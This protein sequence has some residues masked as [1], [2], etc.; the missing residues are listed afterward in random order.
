MTKDLQRYR[1][2]AN[3]VGVLLLLLTAAVIVKYGFGHPGF[4]AVIS[5]IHGFFFLLVY[6]PLAYRLHR[7]AQW[8]TQR[9]LLLL[10]AGIV[11]FA[12]FV[13]ERKVTREL[14]ERM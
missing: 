10:A 3:T 9:L 12:T 1:I 14:Q 11:P 8:P 13:V 2:A 7:L 6:A 5:P 4:S